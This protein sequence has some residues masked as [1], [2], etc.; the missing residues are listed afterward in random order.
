MFFQKVRFV[1]FKGVELVSLKG[2][3]LLSFKRIWSVDVK[4]VSAV[5]VLGREV[6]VVVVVGSRSDCCGC[7]RRFGLLPICVSGGFF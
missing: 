2:G 5:V 4:E 1:V 6:W 7:P 3:G